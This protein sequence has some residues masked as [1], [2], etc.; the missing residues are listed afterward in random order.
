MKRNRFRAHFAPFFAA[1]FVVP[2]VAAQ[3]PGDHEPGQFLVKLASGVSASDWAASVRTEGWDVALISTPSKSSNIHLIAAPDAELEA[4]LRDVGRHPDVV[5]AQLNHYVEERLV[6]NDPGFGQQ[7]HHVQSGDH[8]I[9]SDAA[10][11]ITTGGFTANGDRIVVCVLEGGGSNYNHVD[12]IANHWTNP[13]EIDGNGID[14]DNNG[15]IDDVNGWNSTGNNDNI[16]AGGHGTSV[17]G[18]IGA[19]GNNGTGGAGVNWDVD[20]MQVDMGG[21]SESAVIAA[22]EYPKVMRELYT[23]TGGALGAFV[24]ATNASWGIDGADPAD[25]PLWCAFYDDLGAAGI[26][27]CGA[28]TNSNFNVDTGGDMPTACDSDYMISVTAT[29]NND[30]RTFSGYGATTIDLAA[31]GDN[32]YLPSGSSGYGNTSGTSFAS[33]CVA[34]AIALIY[35]AP[36]A[37]LA[38]LALANPSAA[39]DLVRSYLLDGVDVVPN[40]VGETVTGGRL[41]VANSLNLALANCGPVVCEVEGF[42][43]ETG[44]WY[45]AASMEVATEVAFTAQFS[46]FLCMADSLCWGADTFGCVALADSGWA[47]A[48]GVPLVFDHWQGDEP[49]SVYFVLDSVHSDTLLVELPDCGALVPGCTNPE[50]FNYDAS[51]TIEDGSC[52]LPCTDVV[53]SL[54]TDCY[55]GETTWS[56]TDGDGNVLASSPPFEEA[57]TEYEWTGCLTNTCLTLTVADDYGDGLNGSV[58]FGCDT[59]GT[60]SLTTL[61]GLLLAGMGDPDFGSSVSQGF[62]LPP[63]PGC[64]DAAACN[65]DEAANADDGSCLVVGSPCDDGNVE[66]VNDVIGAACAC[67]GEP[68]VEGCMDAAACNYD[69]AANVAAACTYVAVGAIDF[70][71]QPMAGSETVF[72]YSGGSPGNS[73]AWTVVGGNVIGEATGVDVTSVTVVWDATGVS[74]SVSVVET[75][76]ECSGSVESSFTL[77]PNAVEAWE[78]NGWSAFP[79]PGADGFTFEGDAGQISISDATG[80]LVHQ[81]A[82]TAFRTWI[83]ASAWPAGTYRV[84]A[85]GESGRAVS[86]WVLLR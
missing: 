38:G 10:W 5:A 84:E 9:D 35:S 68:A 24:V 75:N 53:M 52:E 62:C 7:W 60:Y 59:D 76:G 72:N 67:E 74:G 3:A 80:R 69:P 82:L 29:N 61:D 65:F 57:T 20:I 11:D 70:V 49:F 1:F 79:N 14:D 42:G 15:Y 8:D 36:C 81:Q 17:S 64:T 40:L 27:N 71:V 73:Y 45:D 28:T 47:L 19:T 34:G 46:S 30:V 13:N 6:P 26:L 54:T 31:P 50:A 22:Y 77:L 25:Y 63:V 37:D 86:Q 58:W 78:W 66:T 18:M 33:P 56:I 44:C 51:A 43:V 55:P 2:S 32:V 16:A 83:D 41:N 23:E 39:A 12:L 4:V 48:D 21:L 85:I